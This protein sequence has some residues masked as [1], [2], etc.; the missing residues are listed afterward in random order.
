MGPS[1]LVAWLRRLLYAGLFA[2][3][4]VLVGLRHRAGQ[5]QL[6]LPGPTSDG[7]HQIESRCPECHTPL[8]GVTDEAC[9]RCHGDSL[10][11][12]N[13]SHPLARF[14][15]PGKA[16]QLRL[17]DARTC[18]TCHREHRPEARQHGSVTVAADFCF[19][20]H[21]TVTSDRPSHAGLAADSCASSGCHN[22]HDNRATYRDF[23]QRHRGEPELRPGAHV[24]A[25]P[26]WPRPAQ[27]PVAEVPPDERHDGIEEATRDWQA[28]AHAAGQVGCPTCHQPDREWRWTVDDSVCA[29]C[30]GDQ[31]AAFVSGK[32]GMRLAVGLSAMTP[33]TARL[34]MRG[35]AAGKALGCGSCHTAHRYNRVSAA[36]IA[37]EGCHDDSHT[38]AYRASPHFQAWQR[39]LAGD[40]PAG[41]GVSCATCHLPRQIIR[42][43]DR[44]AG[45]RVQHDQNA[46]LRPPDRMARDVC[47]TCHGL[48]FSLAALADPALVARNFRGQPGPVVTG[49][50]LVEKGAA[51][52]GN[53]N[54]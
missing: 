34:P 2:A 29:S 38:L 35:D 46:N 1:L 6:L 41:S 40:A 9:L 44:V 13:D 18:L 47:L 27:P 51:R 33:A 52:D 12:R 28:S 32:H 36:V 24:A 10:S 17:V 49:M 39:E 7:H 11:A 14:D 54:P 42:A 25:L 30:H 15:D 31:R 50:T 19:G 5:D 20:C 45:V 43:R 22:Y 16:A 21:S 48:G 4:V 26:P 53:Q 3:P 37:C 23:L 8:R